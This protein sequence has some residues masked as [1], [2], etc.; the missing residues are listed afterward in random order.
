[1]LVTEVSLRNWLERN[2]R[3]G[4]AFIPELVGRLVAASS[5]N[6]RAFEFP[7][8]DSISRP[9]EDGYLD[10]IQAFEPFVPAGTSYWEF[11]VESPPGH[12][13]TIMIGFRGFT[14]TGH[15]Y[16]IASCRE[17]ARIL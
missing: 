5:K 7:W 4:Q 17:T 8:G 15:Q 11:S 6:P 9:D 16:P 3:D 12:K 10:A 2:P 1:M 14:E 13:S